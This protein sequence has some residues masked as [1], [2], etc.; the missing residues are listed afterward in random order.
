M[1]RPT[2]KVRK[3]RHSETHP[4]L[5]DLRAYGKGRKFYR[6][7]AEAEAERMR[8]QTTLDRHGR[9]AIDL[10][11]RELS[12]F[13]HARNQLAVHGKTI[14]DAANFYIDHLERILRCKTTVSELAAEMIAL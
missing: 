4:F 1:K 6:T 8:Q 5:L 10:A 11:P 3:Y 7:R 13:I 12:A 9:E 2:L 14:T